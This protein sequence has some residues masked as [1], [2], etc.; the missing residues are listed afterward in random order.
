MQG[1]HTEAKGIFSEIR[2]KFEAT[3][4]PTHC[5]TLETTCRLASV[6][7][8][9]EMHSE[10]EKLRTFVF[11]ANLEQRA[12]DDLDTLKTMAALAR[13][14]KGSGRH[15]DAI[16]MLEGCV[17]RYQRVLGPDHVFTKTFSQ[18]SADWRAD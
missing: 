12:P 4:G 2:I 8:S 10:A 15:T 1:R 17:K 9:L 6:Y 14:L 7:E 3:F 16:K 13:T 18:M 11:N 5:K